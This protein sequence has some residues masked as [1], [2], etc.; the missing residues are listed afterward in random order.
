MLNGQRC[1]VSVIGEI[2]RGSNN[3]EHPSQYI[4]VTLSWGQNRSIGMSKPFFNQTQC[5]LERQCH[6]HNFSLRR[7]A[8]ESDQH[9]PSESHTSP[10][11]KS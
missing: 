6:W 11:I 8:N 5:I 1:K 4:C 7:Q 3:Q 2:A 9:K 10:V